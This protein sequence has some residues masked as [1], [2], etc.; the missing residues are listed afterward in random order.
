MQLLSPGL[1]SRRSTQNRDHIS[2]TPLSRPI[3]PPAP[4]CVVR[5]TCLTRRNR[6]GDRHAVRPASPLAARD[7]PRFGSKHARKMVWYPRAGSADAK[8]KTCIRMPVRP[9]FSLSPPA[10]RPTLYDR[11]V[12]CLCCA[13]NTGC[14]E[15]LPGVRDPSQP[16]FPRVFGLER[17]EPILQLQE[18]MDATRVPS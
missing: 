8:L 2:T 1:E 12:A 17:A 11:I 15:G 14:R 4:R 9:Q 18:T 7:T 16:L 3:P 6:G 13:R 10:S 5:R